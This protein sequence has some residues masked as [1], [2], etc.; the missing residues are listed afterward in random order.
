MSTSPHGA[1]SSPRAAS[2]SPRP[3]SSR[4][5]LRTA[6]AAGLSLALGA[7]MVAVGT[8]A[9][10]AAPMAP[11]YPTVF[12]SQVIPSTD[13]EYVAGSNTTMRTA[14]Q[15]RLAKAGAGGV[16]IQSLGAS[17]AFPYNAVGYRAAD[18]YLYGIGASGSTAAYELV[19]IESGG[20]ATSLGA[21]TGLPASGSYAAGAFGGGAESDTLF[22]KTNTAASNIYAVDVTTRAVTR[23]ID[24][25]QDF[26][27]IDFTW[28]NGYLWGVELS[29][30]VKTLVRVDTAGVVDRIATGSLFPA[31]DSS[32]YGAAWTYG[33]GN[34]AFSNNGTGAITQIRVTDPTAATPTLT[35]V[36]TISG[37]STSS[38]DGATS[39]SSAADLQL[40]V[41]QP[42]PAAPSSPVAWSVEVSN[43]GPGGSSGGTFSFTVPTGVTGVTVPTGCTVASAVVQCVS[44]QLADGASDTYAFTGTSPAS[45]SVSTS[46]VLTV[47]GN[48]E[49]LAANTATLVVA[50][51][52][53]ALTTSGIGT[54][55]QTVPAGVPSGGSLTLL[56]G[57]TPV[58]SLTVVGQGTYAL[59]GGSLTFS[60]VLGYVGTAD[61]VSFRVTSST[62]ETGSGTYTPTVVAPPAPSAGAHTSSGVGTA[63]QSTTVSPAPTGGSLV[64]LDGGVPASSVVRAEGTY[65]LDDSTAVI[66]FAPVLGFAGTAPAVAFR[67]T[68]AYA[69]AATGSY[70][71]T[72]TAP[73]GPTAPPKTSSGVG[74][75]PQSPATPVVVPPGGTVTLLDG[76]TPAASV[77]VAGQGTASVTAA[78]ELTFVPVLGFAGE[79]DALGYRVTDA[80]G[81]TATGTYTPTV[82]APASPTAPAGDST[83]VGTADQGYVVVLTPGS[84]VTLLDADG[85]PATSVTVP[86]EGTYTLV[87]DEVHFTPVLG[88]H[89]AAT[90]V[91]IE[92]TDAYGQVTVGTYTPTVV[93]PAPPAAPDLAS[94]GVGTAPQHTDVTVPSSGSVT[95]L[96][97]GLPVTSVTVPGEGTHV[98]DPATGRIT[99]TSVLGFHGAA[100]PVTY[101]VSDAYGQTVDAEYTPTVLTPT[102]P[103]ATPGISQGVGTA[104]QGHVVTVPVAGAVT[105]L[106]LA[107][108]PAT[109]VTVPGEGRYVLDPTTGA[110][111]F[112]PVLGF[113]GVA[114]GVTVRVV[115][116]YGQTADA[117]YVPSVTAPPA[118]HAPALTS[119]GKAGTPQSP[120][121]VVGVP[122][123]G[124]V[125]LLDAAG[126]PVTSLIV[127]GQGTYRLD[128]ATGALTFVPVSGFSGSPTPA[129]YAVTDA[130][131]QVT[132]GTYAP[133]VAALPAAPAVAAPRLATTGSDVL[134][135]VAVAGG[136]LLVGGALLALRR[137]QA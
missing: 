50:R 52:A 120:S 30:S 39:P 118:P 107:G 109:D 10:L 124:S 135:L 6:V 106:D 4:S 5:R 129:R 101:R 108:H 36:S 98:L 29:G 92:V 69:Q 100:T 88:F 33:N 123:G 121:V 116:A 134:W 104:P 95:L 70:T 94:T 102:G 131:G 96:D 61:A 80:Y 56:S 43:E 24:P 77:T 44:G 114:T 48:E 51:S 113:A 91:A 84:T 63:A 38:N 47:V 132:V 85:D 78:G 42:A 9:A 64:L 37:P 31:D 68:D 137:R 117:T 112:T 59:S 79:A 2:L 34:L 87:D 74:T 65:T 99:F 126:N 41:T 82:L 115:D 8:S 110:I 16:E 28:A 62:G 45:S 97:G 49:D 12:I 127:P 19:R 90:P 67:V 122:T 21:I 71:P 20:V 15:S 27:A 73:A 53:Q 3:A 119:A 128:P 46:S 54:A 13:P 76:A 40:T 105:L 58:T 35:K 23:V 89:G 11:L 83:G 18:A 32:G 22:V 66:S 111:T 130:Y 1:A 75:A 7:G 103:T 133:S 55:V 60:P 72:V 57:A 125:T 25:T 26:N 14:V 81:Q 17:A 136:L 86:G 93:A